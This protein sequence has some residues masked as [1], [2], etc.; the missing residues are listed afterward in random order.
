MHLELGT[1]KSVIFDTGLKKKETVKK[2]DGQPILSALFLAFAHF[3]AAFDVEHIGLGTF[4]VF[5]CNL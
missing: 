2:R 5:Y 4:L 3:V 1:R